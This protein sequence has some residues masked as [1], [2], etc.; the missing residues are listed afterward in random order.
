MGNNKKQ[1]I[2]TY[3]DDLITKFLIESKKYGNFECMVD[4]KNYDK[5]KN[6]SWV[7]SIDKY[8]NVKKA[9][10]TINY[11][12]VALHCFI[13]NK[14]GIDHIDRNPLNNLESN[15]RE[16]TQSQ[17]CCNKTKQSNNTSGYKGVIYAKWANLYRVRLQINKKSISVG[18]YK[19]AINAA[20]AYNEAALKYHGEFARLND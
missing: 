16:C 4:T 13:L 18:Y 20:K 10:C 17:N 1:N 9:E 19:T 5:I 15:L 8:K 12:R 3:Q 11:K 6:H 2:I 7:I 14:K